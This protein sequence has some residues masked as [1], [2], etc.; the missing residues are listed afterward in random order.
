M[1]REA[2]QILRREFLQIGNIY[3]FLESITIASASNKVL[4]KRFLKPD[5]IGL[6]PSGG[7]SGNVNYS[8][9]AM[10]WF[11]YRERRTDARYYT[12]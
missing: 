11:V 8:N 4:R 1:L 10:M 7:Y 12:R 9:M 2:C 6:I 5:T 3:V